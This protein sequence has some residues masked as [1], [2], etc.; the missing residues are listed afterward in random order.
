MN[1]GNNGPQF[2]TVLDEM[3]KLKEES[4]GGKGW[5]FRDW[6]REKITLRK[7][8]FSS[9]LS[10]LCIGVII[11][12]YWLWMNTIPITMRTGLIILG[13]LILGSIVLLAVLRVDFRFLIV[14]FLAGFVF[15]LI[16]ESS[17]SDITP[18]SGRAMSGNAV[19]VHE[20]NLTYIIDELNNQLDSYVVRRNYNTTGWESHRDAGDIS[21]D[22]RAG[23]Q[24]TQQQWEQIGEILQAITLADRPGREHRF[25]WGYYIW[26]RYTHEGYFLRTKITEEYAQLMTSF[27]GLHTIYGVEENIAV[28][29]VAF[30]LGFPG[31]RMLRLPL[32]DQSGRLHAENL[33]LAL[34]LRELFL[35]E[36]RGEVGNQGWERAR[37]VLAE[38]ENYVNLR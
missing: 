28:V 25:T 7:I 18:G 15:L 27:S 3:D 38:I 37:E 17:L 8:M 14:L 19:W 20:R 32:V 29:E 13:I 6:D 5:S 9:L 1:S 24:F 2:V 10:I 33:E 36:H 4:K 16:T 11:G 26:V 23:Y 34:Q 35:A 30:P 31:E 21:I 22:I 12:Y